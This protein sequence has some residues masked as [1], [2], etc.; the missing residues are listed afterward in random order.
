[1][2]LINCLITITSLYGLDSGFFLWCSDQVILVLCSFAYRAKLRK[3]ESVSVKCKKCNQQIVGA[4]LRGIPLFKRWIQVDELWRELKFADPYKDTLNVC[5]VIVS[6]SR[7]L[8]KTDP[9][10]S[11]FTHVYQQLP[12]AKS[13]VAKTKGRKCTCEGAILISRPA[14][15]PFL[16]PRN[17]PHSP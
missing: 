11:G 14:V 3:N 6:R 8:I 9:I 7:K 16:I 5:T 15:W 17:F 10:F 1:M 4:E 12:M 13:E 2:L